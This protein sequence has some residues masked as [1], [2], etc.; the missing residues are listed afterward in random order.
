[1]ISHMFYVIN[2]YICLVRNRA[3]ELAELLSDI[4]K[5]RQERKKA[6]ANRAKFVSASSD[7]IGYGGFSGGFSGSFNGGSSRYGGFGNDSYSYCEYR[8]VLYNSFLFSKV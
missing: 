2:I 6:K 3:K 8:S 4:E 5:I 1:M 7:S